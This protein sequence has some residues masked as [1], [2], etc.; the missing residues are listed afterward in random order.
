VA[1]GN[2]SR[3]NGLLAQ[4][5]LRDA[6]GR[7]RRAVQ[8]S[9][10]AARLAGGAGLDLIL[11]PTCARCDQHLPAAAAG[12]LLCDHCRRELMTTTVSSC[13][14]CG[15][16]VPSV[17]G[18]ACGN[19]QQRKSHFDRVFAL[20]DYTGELRAAVLRMKHGADE[21]LALAISALAGE[22]FERPLRELALDVS[23]PVPMHWF[24]R[25]VRGLN[26]PAV[27]AEQ[28]AQRLNIPSS[29]LLVRRRF[30]AI[31]GDLPPS[32]RR[33]NVRNAFRLRYPAYFRGARVLLID[34]VITSGATCD[35]AARIL[36][37]SGAEFVAVLTI[38]RTQPPT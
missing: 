1:A 29:R 30:T 13:P 2:G 15:I 37:R 32:R 16:H 36:K 8:N 38:C 4:A 28:F 21:R 11:P 33:A 20:G 35:E 18:F 25:I 14:R 6:V 10:R 27:V 24:R 26:C 12:G 19:C 31:Q 17:S 34:D 9:R 22:A 5:R 3:R 23:L 7:L